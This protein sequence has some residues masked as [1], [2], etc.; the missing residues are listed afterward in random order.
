MM[1]PRNMFATITACLLL[2][3][4]A[5]SH[6]QLS[7]SAP[8]DEA[9][10]DAAPTEVLL[11]FSEAVRLTAV[12]ITNSGETTSLEIEVADS[13]MEFAVGLPELAPGDYVVEW[14]ALSQDSHVVTGEIRF[15]IAT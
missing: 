2:S 3:G 5:H 15:S 7:S 14:R 1:T 12:S 11:R 13:A 4:I 10:L 8:S 9:V 6:T